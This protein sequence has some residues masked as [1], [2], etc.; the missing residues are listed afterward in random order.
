MQRDRYPR[1]Q[2]VRA[3]PA[4]LRKS[5]AMAQAFAKGGIDFVPMPVINEEDKAAQ[6]A[7]LQRRLDL[8]EK[9][10]Q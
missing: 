1:E 3:N 6:V 9:D 8:I 4:D 7:E 2:R 5:L 10:Q